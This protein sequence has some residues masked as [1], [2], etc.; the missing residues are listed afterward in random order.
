M[1]KRR[2]S[3][4][5]TAID[6]TKA[7][8]A[9]VTN[10]LKQVHK[11][12]MGTA[13]AVTKVGLA[14]SGAAAGLGAFVKVNTDA[15]DRLGKT[16]SKL[17]INVELL[18]QLRFA[19]DQTGIAQETLDMAMQRFIRR[20][21]EAQNG[22]GEA[23]AA[24]EELGIQLKNSDGS[25]KSTK[26]VLFEVA[27]GI[28]NTEDASTR[29]R[30]AFKFFD[31]EG[32]ALVNTL[33]GGSA[34]LNDFFNEA[35]DLGLIIDKQT[36][37]AFEKFADT[38]SILFK[39]I[40]TVV[41]YVIAAF[42]PILQSMAER[43]S[44]LIV[45]AGKLAGGFKS[46][47]R[48]IAVSMVNGLEKAIVAMAQFANGV[49][50]IART[51]GFFEE[52]VIDIDALRAKFDGIRTS[53]TTVKEPL[54]EVNEEIKETGKSVEKLSQPVMA[55]ISEIGNTEKVLAKLTTGTMKKFE[56]SIID[57]LKSG[58][59]EFKKFADYVIE[60][61]LRIAIQRAIIAPITG[62][63]ET[64]FKSIGFEG[65]GF[66]GYGA[67]AGGVDGRGG[68]PAI[69]HPNETVIDHTKGQGMGGATVNFNI[70]AVDATGFD[71]LLASRKGMITAIIN[72]AMNQRG[73]M[74]VV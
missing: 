11:F 67:R 20:V 17:G 31:S 63:V 4:E 23:K 58:K 65:G 22:T 73:K 29:L 26:D 60:Q 71:E 57:S 49:T 72:N 15:I 19:A 53:I 39:Q 42:L 1:A 36:T 52:A 59:L 32:A 43:F 5:L 45:K 10:R 9:A 62:K 41:Q 68:F 40:K 25:F 47:G 24:L 66:T 55:F 35:N 51:F 7:A 38:T 27:D 6:K 44:D 21:G 56:D 16:A 37:A 61:L 8:F 64:F 48:D 70:S 54:E 12:G 14:A 33:K 46:L 30:L 34:G 50:S 13:A 2:V 18:Q 74:G 69:L 28:Q 3:Y